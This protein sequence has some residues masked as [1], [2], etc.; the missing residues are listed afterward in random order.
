MNKLKNII[1]EEIS[2]YIKNN[3]KQLNE[4]L[5]NEHDI[6][7]KKYLSLSDYEKEEDLI[8]R[9]SYLL[10]DFFEEELDN[11]TMDEDDIEIVNASNGDDYTLI[12]QILNGDLN[13]YYQD[14]LRYIQRKVDYYEMPAHQSFEESIPVKNEWLIHFTSDALGIARN[15][16]EYG[17]DD[18][19]SLNY[20]NASVTD[21]KSEGYDFAYTIDDYERFYKGYSGN[22]KYGN[23]AVLFQAS[24][25]K[26]WH[27]G[28]EEY[29]VIFWGRNA[30]N[31]IPIQQNSDGEWTVF[32][33]KTGR[34][35]AKFETL[36]EIVN[37]VL[38]NKEQY[39]KHMNYKRG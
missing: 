6:P 33:S 18:M 15:G 12:D 28:D 10:L 14:F 39:R 4:Y 37:W 11:G 19:D 13:K 20:T 8:Y 16:F 21:G 9:F 27:Y 34:E 31:I 32:S 38:N 17:T 35:L 3:T 7:L 25:I 5:D 26:T 24:G 23:E 29:Q 2:K 36:E 22:P 30:K 1:N